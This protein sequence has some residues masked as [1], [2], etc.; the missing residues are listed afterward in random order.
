MEIDDALIDHIG[1][2]ARLEFAGEEREQ[3]KKDLGNM[4]GLIDRI[5]QLDTEG[6][7]PLIHMTLEQSRYRP[8]EEP[9]HLDRADAL[10]NAPK[11]D[12]DYFR[13]PR[14]VDK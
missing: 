9:K 11:A 14:F 4:L 12:S 1:R 7:E 8:A 5:A 10:S 13:V 3:I 2:L 6:V